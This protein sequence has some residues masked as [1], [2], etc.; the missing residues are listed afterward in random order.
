MWFFSG[1]WEQCGSMSFQCYPWLIRVT[2]SIAISSQVR[3]LLEPLNSEITTCTTICLLLMRS[4]MTTQ[5]VSNQNSK[6]KQNVFASFCHL[7]KT[8]HLWSTKVMHHNLGLGDD[9][10]CLTFCTKYSTLQCLA[11]LPAVRNNAEGTDAAVSVETSLW[12]VRRC[13]A[14][15]DVWR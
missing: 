12:A 2:M 13:I 11:T 7:L 3:L 6:H 14:R 5:Q 8:F 15:V 1:Q 4:P 9:T 10:L